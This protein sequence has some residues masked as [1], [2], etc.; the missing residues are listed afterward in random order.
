MRAIRPVIK[1]CPRCPRLGAPSQL[2]PPIVPSPFQSHRQS[3]RNF[4]IGPAI[5][6]VLQGSQ[7]LILSFHTVT[8]TPWF[9]TIP[10]VSLGVNLLFRLPLNTYIHKIQHRRAKLAPILQAW[11]T[12]IQ[13]EIDLERVLPSRRMAEVEAR[14]SRISSRIWK[15]FG[16]Q[17]WKLYTNVLGLPFWL[18]GIDAVRRLCGGPAGIL[19][20]LFLGAGAD[21]TD[22]AATPAVG[23]KPAEGGA[24]NTAM[25]SGTGASGTPADLVPPGAPLPGGDMLDTVAHTVAES[26]LATGGVLWFPDLTVPD[27]WH[28]LPLTLSAVLVLNLWPKTVAQRQ[29]VFN[30]DGGGGPPAAASPRAGTAP[31]RTLG[32]KGRLSLQRGLLVVSFL[33]GPLTMNLPAALHMYWITSSAVSFATAKVLTR[34]YPVG[35]NAVEA[36]KGIELPVVRPKRDTLQANKTAKGVSKAVS[37]NRSSSS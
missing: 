29:A 22:A 9:I 20:R 27:P 17:D 31:M 35:G 1:A 10:L 5:G 4:H 11:G 2:R 18:I 13:R 36:C 8:H 16:L 19:G 15:K 37:P 26:S 7:D 30:I 21:Q 28:V 25:L 14:F 34:L 32:M 3:H 6:T 23:A 33:V 24:D 12:R